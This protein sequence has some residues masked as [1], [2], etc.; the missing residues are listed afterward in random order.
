MVFLPD[1]CDIITECFETCGYKNKFSDK[2]DI[3]K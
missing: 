1:I 2:F 3:Q